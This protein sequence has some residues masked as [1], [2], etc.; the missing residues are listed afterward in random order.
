M[1]LTSP[2]PVVR[3][4]SDDDTWL[5]ARRAGAGGSDIAAILDVSRYRSSWNVWSEKTGHPAWSPSEM[6]V[7]AELGHWLE[8]WLI[9]QAARFGAAAHLTDARTYAHPSASW[10][11]CSPDAIDS[12]GWLIECKTG[13]LANRSVSSAWDDGVPVE[14]ELQARWNTH[15]MD[16]PGCR[17]IALVGG[18]G[19][20]HV[21][22]PRDR[23]IENVLVDTV[24]RW[25]ERYVEGSAE[26]GVVGIDS[27]ALS[28][29]FPRDTDPSVELDASG[30]DL[31]V[32]YVTALRAERS[33]KVA[34]QDARAKLQRLMKS[35]R[36]ATYGGVPIAS[37][38]TISTGSRRFHI[39]TAF[40]KSLSESPSPEGVES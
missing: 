11:M 21:E 25:W 19:L 7:A 38:S 13:G 16:A 35:S 36:Y 33:A 32:E 10:R 29:W 12:N 3:W 31:A 28:R 2:D 9:E 24:S 4:D 8:P 37:W 5:Q 22:F 23:D 17:L 27:E 15:V 6:S 34:K 14:Y 30:R 26:P 40:V 18:Y 1:V 20:I 39:P